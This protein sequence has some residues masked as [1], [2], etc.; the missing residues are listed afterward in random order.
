MVPV[1]TL[2]KNDMLGVGMYTPVEAAAFIGT[3]PGQITR[4][5]HGNR[6]GDP[7]VKAQFVG[8]KEVFTFLDLVQAMAVKAMRKEGYSLQFI[9]GA[10]EWTSRHFPDIKYPFAYNHKT[11]LIKATKEIAVVPP[12]REDLIQVSGRNEGQYVHQG[13][14]DKYLELLDFSDH[15][16]AI[17]YKPLQR[18]ERCIV[19]DPEV[20]CGQPRVEPCGRLVETLVCAANSEGS[21]AAAASVYGVKKED[22]EIALDYYRALGWAA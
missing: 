10:A 19:L 2:L 3:R 17:R 13:M 14:L 21:V 22:V 11:Y 18:G 20:R 16:L 15:G 12:G 5:I 4:W 6:Q 7:A 1:I 8:H 9:R